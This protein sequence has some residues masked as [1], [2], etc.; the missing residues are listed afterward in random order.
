MD[1]RAY[2]RH[3]DEIVTLPLEQCRFA[4]RTS[5][6]NSI[7]RERYIVLRVSYLL[8][9]DGVPTIDYIDLQKEFEGASTP[10]TLAAVRRAVRRIRERKAMLLVEGDPDCRSA[11]SFFKNPILTEAEFAELQSCADP[12]LPRYAAGAGQVKT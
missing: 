3:A 10:P 8:V 6:F 7:A 4:Y 11:G 9:N 2:D 5:V 1:V 12:G